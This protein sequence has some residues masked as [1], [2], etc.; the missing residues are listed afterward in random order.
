[1]L[2]QDEMLQDVLREAACRQGVQN[3]M[4]SKLTKLCH[5]FFPE[6]EPPAEVEEAAEG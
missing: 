2:A 4:K 6:L 1:M 5:P 3:F